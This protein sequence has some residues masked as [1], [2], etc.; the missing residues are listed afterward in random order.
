MLLQGRIEPVGRMEE[1]LPNFHD[2]RQSPGTIINVTGAAGLNMLPGTAGYSLSKLV[3]TQIQRFVGLENPNVVAVSLHPGL[4]LRDMTWPVMVP[5][6]KHTPG[7][8]GGVAVWLATEGAKFMN[9]C[10]LGCGSAC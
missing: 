8:T 6:S 3:D 5:F 9:G 7:L 4:I 10:E 2:T 1:R